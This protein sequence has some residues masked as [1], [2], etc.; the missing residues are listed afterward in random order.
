MQ[1]TVR[2]V[3]KCLDVSEGIVVRWVKQRSLPA[4][5]VGGQYRFNRAEVLEWAT[6]QQ[7]KVSPE[8]FAHADDDEPVPGLVS[9]IEA[10]GIHYRLRDSN[11]ETAL[12][13]LVAILPLPDTVDR[14]MLLGLFLARE[15][16]SSTGIGGGI[17]VP[18][19]RRPIVLHVT[20]PMISVAFIERPVDFGAV[21]GQPVHALFCL[22]SPTVQSHLK[23]LSRLS[24]ALHDERFRGVVQRQGLA[25]EILAEARRVEA[26]LRPTPGGE[27]GA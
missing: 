5:Q 14:Q 10:G 1:L 21:D 11:K 24:F 16:L 25:E 3:S 26:G 4:Q 23:L 20:R 27:A 22:I 18:H 7:I 17:A 13:A 15:A 8:L 12:R 9:A 6:S 2:D 19:V